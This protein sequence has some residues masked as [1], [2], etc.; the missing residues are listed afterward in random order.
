MMFLFFGLRTLG[1]E[2]VLPGTVALCSAHMIRFNSRAVSL[3]GILIVAGLAGAAR[4]ASTPGVHP[5]SGRRFA[6]VMGY[7][8]ADW[9]DR[10]ERMTEEE[11][12]KALGA[13]GIVK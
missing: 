1:R 4:Q 8:G 2:G 3:A 9:L 10:T 5:I 13:L 11:P 7:Q 12:D 6:P